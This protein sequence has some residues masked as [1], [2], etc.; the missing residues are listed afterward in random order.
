MKRRQDAQA[1]LAEACVVR[2]EAYRAQLARC[3]RDPGDEAVHDLRVAIR[4]LVAL[5]ELLRELLPGTRLGKVRRDLKRQF[6]ELG[7][8]RDT[9]VMHDTLAREFQRPLVLARLL[10]WLG[11]RVSR[12]RR[13]VSRDLRRV[14]T[15]RTV[16]RL[17]AVGK[18]LQAGEA[19]RDDPLQALDRQFAVVAGEAALVDGNRPD[20][21]HRLRIA[22]KRFRYRVEI[23]HP[24]V[25]GYP[26]ARLDAMDAFQTLMGAVQDATVLRQTL[27]PRLHRAS[28]PGE[29]VLVRWCND[30][31]H[32]LVG[33]FLL[34]SGQW[35][36]C[37][38]PGPVLPFPW[39]EKPV[40]RR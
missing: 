13:R 40:R 2:L 35:Q 25:L 17:R 28:Q 16:R 19:L 37:W 31:E 27:L 39:A 6:R 24:L 15:G 33:Q 4:R 38:R 14:R 22:F 18:R 9:Q 5:V 8:L 12:C 7:S 26:R 36:A 23:L 30:R 10:P 29:A 3:R 21:I 32:R 11:A 34:H 20:T 1:L